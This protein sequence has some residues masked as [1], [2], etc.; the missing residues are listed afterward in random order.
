MRDDLS[1]TQPPVSAATARLALKA[2]Q[3]IG[4]QLTLWGMPCRW[5]D[6]CVSELFRPA[7]ARY[8][9]ISTMLL[10]IQQFASF[11]SLL[12]SPS[13]SGAKTVETKIAKVLKV[14]QVQKETRHLA[15]SA[16]ELF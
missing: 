7:G 14:H 2:V 3:Q 13:F 16:Y 6:I 9:V 11:L 12:L 8:Y 10:V 4:S 15:P 1:S 5:S